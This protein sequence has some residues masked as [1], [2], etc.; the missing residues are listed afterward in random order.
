MIQNLFAKN[1]ISNQLKTDFEELYRE[2]ERNCK[3]CFK[4]NKL[5]AIN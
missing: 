4:I 2:I 1:E 5:N 3:I